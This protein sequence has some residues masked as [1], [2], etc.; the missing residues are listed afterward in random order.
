MGTANSQDSVGG[1]SMETV[2]RLTKNMGQDAAQYALWNIRQ[3]VDSAGQ[4]KLL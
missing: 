2:R 1:G 4:Q 3:D